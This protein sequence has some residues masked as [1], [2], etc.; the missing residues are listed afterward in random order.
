MAL[1]IQEYRAMRSGNQPGAQAAKPT[2]RKKNPEYEIQA[3]Y[4]REISRLFPSVMVFS[5]TAAHIKKTIIQQV[6]ANKLST[7]V[8]WPDVFV[9]QPSGQYAGLYLEFKAE[10]PYLKDGITLSSDKHLKA[11]AECLEMLEAR[12]YKAC[13]VWTV[14]DAISITDKYLNE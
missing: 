9:A 10:S 12:G 4:V 8:K 5:D 13:F 11:Q 1:S 3:E 14:S 2:K 6:R 7:G